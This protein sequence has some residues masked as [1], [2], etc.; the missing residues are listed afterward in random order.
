MK[1]YIIIYG[2]LTVI[3]TVIMAFL[4]DTINLLYRKLPNIYSPQKTTKSKY[5]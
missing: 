3:M 5:C 4:F 1:I 2:T